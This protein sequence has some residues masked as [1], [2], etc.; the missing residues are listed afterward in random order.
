M[1]IFWAHLRLI[2]FNR[3]F[4]FFYKNTLVCNTETLELF[5]YKGRIY[6]KKKFSG[7]LHGQRLNLI[8]I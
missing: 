4:F 1:A 2:F 5:K 6:K 7:H 3:K 8:L